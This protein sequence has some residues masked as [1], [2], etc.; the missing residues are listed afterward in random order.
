MIWISEKRYYWLKLEEGF[1]NEKEIKKLRRI[2][3]GDT[4]TIIYLKMMLMSL[5]FEGK[6]FFEGVEETFIEELALMLDEDIDNVKVTVSYLISTGLMKEVNPIEAEL[7]KIPSMIGSE[8]ASAAR[9]RRHRERLKEL[10]VTEGCEQLPEDTTGKALQ[11]NSDV[12]NGNTDIDIEKETD[13]HKEEIRE[14]VS[15]LNEKI[16]SRYRPGTEATKK[17]INARLNEGFTVDD[18]KT[19]IDIKADEWLGNK[20]MKKYLRPQTLFGTN[21]ESYL[22]QQTPSK[23]KTPSI[24]SEEAKER[25]LAFEEIQRREREEWE[26]RHQKA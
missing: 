10:K 4:Y 3:G 15:Y 18:C 20:D 9:V 26:T 21:F 12:T 16:G 17:H 22:N 24:D 25:S 2:A 8:Q 6:L 19:V 7:T 1:F 11:S 23:K 13:T 5:Q 14:I